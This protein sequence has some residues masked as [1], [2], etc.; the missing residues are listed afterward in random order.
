MVMYLT[1]GKQYGKPYANTFNIVF[2]IVF[3]INLKSIPVLR[4]LG[5]ECNPVDNW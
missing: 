3:K 2:I 5:G 4:T 1:K